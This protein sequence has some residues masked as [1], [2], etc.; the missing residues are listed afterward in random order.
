MW[1]YDSSQIG[2]NACCV[3]RHRFTELF[4]T[5]AGDSS[6]AA[7]AGAATVATTVPPPLVGH[8]DSVHYSY[9]SRAVFLFAGETV[10]ELVAAAAG[11]GGGGDAAAAAAA[12]ETGRWWRGVVE[13]GPWY[14][15]WYDICDV[16]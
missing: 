7:A 8:V 1:V 15:I 13:A 11:G 2:Q 3:A 14:N 9:H 4:P 6:A 5:L 12:A 16:E 10:Y